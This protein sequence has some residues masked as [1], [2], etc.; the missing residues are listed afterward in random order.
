MPLDIIKQ[1]FDFSVC[2]TCKPSLSKQLAPYIKLRSHANWNKCIEDC[3]KTTVHLISHKIYL[4]VINLHSHLIA[5][6][7]KMWTSFTTN[8]I[9][10][11]LYS[12]L[13][14]KLSS[15]P[16]DVYSNT[17]HLTNKFKFRNEI[18]YCKVFVFLRFWEFCLV[19]AKTKSS[20]IF[21]L[22]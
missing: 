4:L 20:Q 5:L 22:T 15:F 2:I 9:H 11:F 17:L 7:L 10:Q 13:V 19:F 6:C 18:K 3:W 1:C 14:F 12:S 16:F 8:Y 21:I